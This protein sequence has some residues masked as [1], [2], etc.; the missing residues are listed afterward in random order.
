MKLSDELLADIR[1]AADIA[2]T[3]S[4]PTWLKAV[5]DQLEH[6]ARQIRGEVATVQMAKKEQEAG[7]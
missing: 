3:A 5:A 2:E 4:T 6:L 7:Q 1:L